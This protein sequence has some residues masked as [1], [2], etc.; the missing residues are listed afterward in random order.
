MQSLGIAALAAYDSWGAEKIEA[1]NAITYRGLRRLL[2]EEHEV[3][4]ANGTMERWL[5][6]LRGGAAAMGRPKAT[7]R[8]KVDMKRPA[9]KLRS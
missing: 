5:G 6:R 4:A 9:A 7:G 1:D 8:P 2:E 3:T